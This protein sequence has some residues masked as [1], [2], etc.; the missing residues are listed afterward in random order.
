MSYAW[1]EDGH[2]SPRVRMFVAALWG[3]W[4]HRNNIVF[5]KGMLNPEQLISHVQFL[6]EEASCVDKVRTST[7]KTPSRCNAGSS[8]RRQNMYV[9]IGS[10]NTG[11]KDNI[12]WTLFWWMECGVNQRD[13]ITCV[14]S[15]GGC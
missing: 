9:W 1:R 5:R 13:Q 14:R 3:I 4:T 11:E 10:Q 7:T 15:L 6:F 2:D 8:G 12:M